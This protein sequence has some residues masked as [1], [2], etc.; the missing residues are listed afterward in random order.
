MIH[1]PWRHI[2]ARHLVLTDTPRLPLSPCPPQVYSVEETLSHLTPALERQVKECFL[3]RS[4]NLIPLLRV[5]DVEFKLE[6]MKLFKPIMSEA[7]EEII[8]KGCLSDDVLFLRQGE[9]RA[10][11]YDRTELF[12]ISDQGR[13][14]GENVLLRRACPVTYVAFTRCE[15]FVIAHKALAGLVIKYLTLPE[16]L[17]LNKEA[18]NESCRKTLIRFL[19]LRIKLC[20]L[21][22]EGRAA[23]R[24]TRAALALQAA[25]IRRRAV[26]TA[27]GPHQ[28]LDALMWGEGGV[29]ENARESR[30]SLGAA[31]TKSA[32]SAQSA[33]SAESPPASDGSYSSSAVLAGQQQQRDAHAD[34]AVNSARAVAKI[35]E[36]ERK[37]G[38]L[39]QH[40]GRIDSKLDSVMREHVE[41]TKRANEAA[42]SQAATAARLLSIDEKLSFIS[43]NAS[44]MGA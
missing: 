23:T 1:G 16:R 15:L 44:L 34:I 31:S 41:A 8:P 13:F 17:R 33:K 20:E 36:V 5:Y 3:A 6:L 27:Y 21:I 4:V 28:D 32:K 10:I 40:M 39:K 26:A 2:F 35:L 14:F 42:A 22:D 38:D 18:V 30:T 11:A 7:S 12:H 9:V 19:A 37:V 25:V 24:R 29:K 43:Q